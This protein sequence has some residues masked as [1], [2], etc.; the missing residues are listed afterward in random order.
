MGAPHPASVPPPPGL[1]ISACPNPAPPGTSEITIEF[2]LEVRVPSVNL[3]I[4]NA[5][6]QTVQ[7]L[8]RDQP[9][10]QNTIFQVSWPLEGVPSGDY[11][12]YFLAGSLE[13]SGDI[14]LQ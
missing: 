10:P 13:T 9:A 2:L 14:Q 3:A 11:R 6:G 8:M 12:A 4:V 5:S 7:V 1:Q